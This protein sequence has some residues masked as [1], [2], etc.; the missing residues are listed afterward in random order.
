[1][2]KQSIDFIEGINNDVTEVNRLFISAFIHAHQLKIENNDFLKKY[3][4]SKDTKYYD[5]VKDFLSTFKDVNNKIVFPFELLIKLFEFVVSPADKIVNG[6]IYTPQNI[7][8]YI[9]KQSFKELSSKDFKNVKIGD[10]SCGCGGFLIDASIELKKQTGKSFRAIFEENIFGIDIKDYCIERTKILLSLLAILEGEDE[11]EFIFNLYTANSLEFEL[12]KENSKIKENNGLDLILGNPPYV[13]SRNMDTKTKQLMRKL[14]SCKTGHPDLYIAFFEIGYDLLARDGILGFITVN[15]F[16]HSINGRAIR[17]FFRKNKVD[18]KI[19]DFKGEQIFKSRMTYTCICII[20]KRKSDFVYYV[21]KK[22]KELDQLSKM[23]FNKNNY[24]SL[25]DCNGWSLKNTRLISKLESIGT[26][27]GEIYNTKSGIATLKNS[28]YIF[29]PIKEDTQYYYML[30]NIKIEKAICKDIVNPNQLNSHNDF[31][32]IKEKIIFPYTHNANNQAQIIEEKVL[33]NKFPGAYAY[34][35]T[36]QQLLLTRDKGNGKYPI[37]YAFGRSQS[38]EKCKNKL[39]FPNLVKKGFNAILSN[40]ENLYFYNGMAAFAKEEKK[41]KILQKILT[42]DVIW[43]YIEH[44]GK[45]YASNYFGL[46]KNYLKNLGIYNFEE[47]EI[48]SLLNLSDKELNKL[49]IKKYT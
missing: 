42:S 35:L 15:T 5:N 45:H 22:E 19:I 48:D 43:D 44:K 26:P 33:A 34:L 24:D 20:N 32:S 8:N 3:I 17:N 1:M 9:T 23:K 37:W 25:N 14:D 4:I 28:V 39:F 2:N 31:E 30:N 46:G 29:K 27:F 40:D 7:R 11:R 41:L 18:L 12:L 21:S 38:L 36:K 49:L 13:C 16:M 10:I 6:A 47:E